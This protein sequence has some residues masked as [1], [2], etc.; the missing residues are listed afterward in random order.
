[1]KQEI[2]SMAPHFEDIRHFLASSSDFLGAMHMNLQA[3]NAYLWHDE[4]GD[5][6]VGGPGHKSSFRIRR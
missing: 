6:D 4:E 3:D 2:L 1:M 5:L